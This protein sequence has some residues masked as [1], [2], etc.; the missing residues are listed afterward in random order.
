MSNVITKKEGCQALSVEVT[1]DALP[2]VNLPIE[3]GNSQIGVS[4]RNAQCATS[5]PPQNS[6]NRHWYALR[7][8]Y[9]R[10]KKAFDFIIANNGVA[11]WPTITVAKRDVDGKKRF[12]LKSRIPNVLFAY[13]TEENIT[14]FVNDNINLPFLRFYYRY[15][16]LDMKFAKSH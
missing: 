3:A 16:L 12:V 8:T 1:F 9:G 6:E 2:E 14:N 4:T 15:Y 13:G 5:L 7:T 11:F 10:E